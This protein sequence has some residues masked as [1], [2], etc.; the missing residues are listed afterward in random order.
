MVNMAMASTKA[1][2]TVDAAAAIKAAARV[3]FV[4]ARAL[5]PQGPSPT[6]EGSAPDVEPQAFCLRYSIMTSGAVTE[7]GSSSLPQSLMPGSS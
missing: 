5:I 1:T 7:Y 6:G 4:A 2:V 3:I